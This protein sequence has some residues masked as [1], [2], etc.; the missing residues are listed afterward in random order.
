MLFHPC[1][2]YAYYHVPYTFFI[3]SRIADHSGLLLILRSCVMHSVPS[4]FYLMVINFDSLLGVD[5][6]YLF[7]ETCCCCTAELLLQRL[8][9]H[10]QRDEQTGRRDGPCNR[11]SD[12]GAI[13]TAAIKSD[14]DRLGCRVY[15]IPPRARGSLDV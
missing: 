8:R 9:Q 5:L 7:T 12:Y 15:T 3:Q 11:D 2:R 6:K 4:L 1:R 10:H 13:Q 14:T